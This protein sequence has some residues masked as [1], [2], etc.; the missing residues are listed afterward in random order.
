MK[1]QYL[2]KIKYLNELSKPSTIAGY[3][4]T[5][6]IYLVLKFN[7]R[8]ASLL[9]WVAFACSEKESITTDLKPITSLT[10]L[11]ET[12]KANW[13]LSTNNFFFKPVYNEEQLQVIESELDSE[14]YL[15]QDGACDCTNTTQNENNSFLYI[16]GILNEFE[17]ESSSVM[18]KISVHFEN[19][20]LLA[21]HEV[22]ENR[23]HTTMY[24]YDGD[25]IVKIESGLSQ[26]TNNF[27]EKSL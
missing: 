6:L 15:F 23:E 7:Y 11:Q 12:E 27:W 18:P 4:N 21:V 17:H 2:L 5:N 9:L 26:V 24:T 13:F 20:R 14:L 19:N 22:F 10:T 25:K 1:F 3:A 16:N 8:I